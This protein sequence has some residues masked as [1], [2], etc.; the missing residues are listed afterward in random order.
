[1]LFYGQAGCSGVLL[2][3]AQDTRRVLSLPNAGAAQ[4]ATAAM[5]KEYEREIEALKSRLTQA[6]SQISAM[7]RRLRQDGTLPVLRQSAFVDEIKSSL[8]D[9]QKRPVERRKTHAAAGCL[10]EVSIVNLVALLERYGDRASDTVLK[11]VAGILGGSL[12]QTDRIGRLGTASFG[13]LLAFSDADAIE[14]KMS[15]ICEKIESTP[16]LWD[17][18]ELTIRVD[19]RLA[20]LE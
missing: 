4:V 10:V 18:R 20:R 15:R 17:E 9:Q 1:M 19:Y 8:K 5:V 16:A 12:R 6:K 3:D 14:K 7:Q 2:M 11:H 13:I